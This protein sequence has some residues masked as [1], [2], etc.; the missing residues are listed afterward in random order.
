MFRGIRLSHTSS[1]DW[2][3]APHPRIQGVHVAT[4]GS[5]HAWKFLPIMG[6]LV[7]DS[8]HGVLPPSLMKKW[9]YAPKGADMGNAS[10]LRGEIKELRD[11]VRSSKSTVHSRL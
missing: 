4:G 6:D 7:L 8:I 10:M 5:G 11:F 9:A 3:I 2:I 1:S